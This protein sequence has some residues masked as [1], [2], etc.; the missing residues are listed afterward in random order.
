[1]QW[2]HD[3]NNSSNNKTPP[4]LT[5]TCKWGQASSSKGSSLSGSQSSGCGGNARQIFA[6]TIA[7]TSGITA[8]VNICARKGRVEGGRRTAGGGGGGA[9]VS[10]WGGY[11]TSRALSLWIFVKG[12]EREISRKSAGLNF[13]CSRGVLLSSSSILNIEVEEQRVYAVFVGTTT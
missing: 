2:Q 5:L 12:V 7:I 3:S 10:Y 6:F 11:N 13:P 1:M 9:L 8:G 4:N